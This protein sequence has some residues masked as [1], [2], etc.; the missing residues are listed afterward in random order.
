MKDSPSKEKAT[1]R[2]KNRLSSLANRGIRATLERTS[3]QKVY[4]TMVWSQIRGGPIPEHIGVI[5]DGNRR[6]ARSRGLA[7]WKGHEQGARKMEDFLDWCGEISDIRSIT[8]YAFSTENFKRSERE[9]SE[10]FRLLKEYL[11]SLLKDERVDKNEIRVKMLGR[12][13]MLPEEFQE[14]IRQVEEKTADYRKHYFNFAI[15]YGGRTEIVDAVRSLAQNVKEE[16]LGLEDIDERLIENYLYT[17]HL[18]KCSPDLIIRT[19]GEVRL[20]NFLTWQG[21][22]SEL[23]FVDVYWPDFRKLDLLRAIRMYQHRQRRFGG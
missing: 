11:N 3:V 5:L 13:E 20:S 14:L 21:A 19:S 22:Y 8:L 1:A 6:W 15:A 17:A 2:A 23:C 10:I 16:K 12:I 4:E 7:P 9:V 18:P